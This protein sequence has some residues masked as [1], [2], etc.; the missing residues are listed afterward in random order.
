[1]DDSA[2]PVKRQQKVHR[3]DSNLALACVLAFVLMLSSVTIAL[4][5]ATAQTDTSEALTKE[6]DKDDKKKFEIVEATIGDIHKAIKAG[7]VTCTEIVQQYIDRAKAYNGVCTQLVTEDGAPVPPSFGRVIVGSPQVFPTETV[8]VSSILPDLDQYAG[9]PLDLGR[10]ETTVSDPSVQHQ[11]GM[12]VGI[13]DVGQLNALETLNI[14]GERSV[15][16]K[17]EFDAHPSTGPLPAGAPEVCEEFRQ[18]PDALERAA[19]LDAQYGS[20]PPLD[21]LPM[22]CITVGVKDPYDTKDMRSTSNNDVNFAMDVPPFDSTS[23]ERLREKGAI[24]YAKTQAHE[25]SAGPGDPGGPNEAT[26][27]LVGEGYGISTW[28][29]QS[30]NPYDTERVP[31]GSS[32]GSGPAVAANLVTV[33]LCEQS[34]ASCQGPAS[35]SGIA[36]I[37]TTQGLIP[38]AGGQGFQYFNDRQGINAKTLEEAAIVLDAMKDP[39]DGYFD[40]KGLYTAIPKALI[41]EEPYANFVIGDEDLEENSKPLEGMR[42]ALL[43]EHFVTPTPNHEAMSNQ[44]DNETKTI[45]RDKLGAELVE[46]IT[47]GYPDDPDVPN[48]E[49]TFSD[50]FSEIFPRYIP[51]IFSR[52]DSDGNPLFAVPGWNVTSYEYLLA[53]SNRQAPISEDIMIHQL[54]NI[55]GYPNQ[56]FFKFEIDRY[57]QQRGDERVTDWASWVENAKF[58]QDSSRAGAENWVAT[59]TTLAEGKSNR[60]AVSDLARLALMKVM[61]A[62][63]VD[64]FVHPENTVPPNK[65]GGPLVGSSSLDGITPFMQIPR[66]VVP[67]GFNQIV[68][69]PRFALSEDKTDYDSV[70]GTEQTLLPHPMPVTITFFAGQGEEPTL[71]KIATAYEAATHHRV[72]PPDFGPLSDDE[73]FPITHMSNT[74]ASAGYGVYAQKP[75]RAEY[76]TEESELVG[77]KIDSITLRMKSVGT[78]NGTAEIGILNDDLSVKKLFGT[79][80]VTTLTP[81]YTDYEFSLTGD[82]LYTIESGDRIGIKYTGGGFDETSWVSVML[83]LDA[84]DP[85]DGANSY[86]QYHYQG[87]WRSSPDRDMHMTLVQ[88]HG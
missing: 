22:Y 50:A 49:Y 12:R 67:A 81:T 55:V 68:Y 14:R 46:S 44:I 82:E 84:E 62:N 70:A 26:S 36:L 20:N 56:L 53:L 33:A 2:T 25:F 7:D 54:G 85:F 13:S 65:I 6:G 52:T 88:T 32:S 61:F 60:M 17:G 30:C 48:L 59:N 35:R 63:D 15:T 57:L 45:L 34:G 9:L 16:C 4:P 47:P 38:D 31:R 39:E 79:L 24:I 72:P 51:E 11:M 58:R 37:L 71:I 23:V 76:V 40:I 73:S 41:P 66:V 87:S 69:E 21:E 42:I 83:D 19:E 1:M 43:R 5:V 8:P 3:R 28:A 86:L 74:T 75:A 10:M 27:N 80:D 29:G 18:Q 64:A 77:D 78:I